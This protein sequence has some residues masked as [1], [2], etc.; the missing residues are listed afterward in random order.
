MVE[1]PGFGPTTVLAALPAEVLAARGGEAMS[2]FTL[3]PRLPQALRSGAI[4]VAPVLLAACGSSTSHP[5]SAGPPS[6]TPRLYQVGQTVHGPRSMDLKVVSV[7]FDPVGNYLYFP[8]PGGGRWVSVQM[9]MH[10]G[11][12]EAYA[13]GGLMALDFRVQDS[14]GGSIGPSGAQHNP[15]LVGPL[16]PGETASGWMSF[17]VPASGALRLLWVPA[18]AEVQ[19]AP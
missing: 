13:A 5:S 6:S 12:S 8:L 10:N 2:S 15:Q 17:A 19:L 7:V 14:Q 4:L 18:S 1:D 3:A 11:G 9:T 16:L